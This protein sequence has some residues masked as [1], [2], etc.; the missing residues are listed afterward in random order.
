MTDVITPLSEEEIKRDPKAEGAAFNAWWSDARLRAGDGS[1]R[2]CAFDGFLAGA[3]FERR[4]LF[5]TL[6]HERGKSR[7]GGGGRRDS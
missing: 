1:W 4:R 3:A 2:G 7:T 6:A 5:A